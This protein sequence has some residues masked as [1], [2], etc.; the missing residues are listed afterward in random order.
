MTRQAATDFS[1]VLGG[2]LY[3][4]W[5]RTRL[6]GD[7]LELLHRRIVVLTTVAWVPLLA[8]S[9]A[10]G[11]VWGSVALPFLHDIEM[12]VDLLV[13]LPLLVAAELIVHR[14]TV[15]VVR[16]FFERGLIP[17]SAQARFDAALASAIRWRNSIW[18]EVL[19]LAFVYVVGV[20]VVWRT[21]VALSVTSWHG[22]PVNGAWQPSLAGWWL[23]LVSVPVFQFLLFRW[24]FRQFIW[25]RFLWHVSRIELRLMPTHPDRSGGMGFVASVVYAF[26]PLL[27]AQGVMLAGLMASRILFA[28]AKL[29][30]FKVE[31][32]ML[33]AVMV[34][35]VLGPLLFF[36][37]Q[38]EAAKRKGLREHGILAQRYVREYDNKWLR[39]GAVPD[40]P[41]VG[42]AD[43]QS[44]AD[45]SNSY[46]VLR[47][48]RWVPFSAHTVLQLAVTTLLPALPLTLTMMPL[49]ELLDR[50]L[51]IVF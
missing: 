31:L 22:A 12:H 10:E 18:A 11:H 7:A 47:D 33:V 25:A 39:A 15:P 8:L 50:L 38:L 49:E 17:D 5:R 29:P 44:L 34:F 36:S 32:I 41:L 28:G 9:I 37:P 46:E 21:Q 30:D 13:A 35:A 2:P 14:R 20:G 45:L 24:Y 26:S 27:V 6:S 4:L 43:I 42:S 3:Q 51:Q 16:Q 23:V 1:L 40:E 19:L 48:M